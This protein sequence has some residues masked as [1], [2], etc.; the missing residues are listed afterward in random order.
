MSPMTRTQAIG[1]VGTAMLIPLSWLVNL[2]G[3][4]WPVGAEVSMTPATQ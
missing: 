1:D 2:L 4:V 3:S